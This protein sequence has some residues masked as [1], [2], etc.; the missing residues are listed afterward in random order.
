MVADRATAVASG[1]GQ[2]ALYAGWWP[3]GDYDEDD[4]DE[5]GDRQGREQ[6]Y[7]QGHVHNESERVI[8]G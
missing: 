2:C 3:H 7:G 1:A 5:H 4:D 6:E 8:I